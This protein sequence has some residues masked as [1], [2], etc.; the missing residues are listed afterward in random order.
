MWAS[1]ERLSKEQNFSVG[2]N[3]NSD[4]FSNDNS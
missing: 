3:Q 2:E 4:D 1:S